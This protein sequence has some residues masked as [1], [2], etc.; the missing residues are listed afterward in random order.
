[1]IPK[2]LIS[3]F[4]QQSIVFVDSTEIDVDSVILATGYELRKPFLDA[5][6]VLVTNPKVRS[7]ET[8]RQALVSNTNYIF[9]LYRHIFS[10]SPTYPTT[11]LS[12]VGLPSAIANC[13]SDIAQSL[14]V[15]YSIRDPSILPSRDEMLYDLGIQEQKLRDEGLNPYTK[16]HRLPDGKRAS[17]YQDELVEYLEEKVDQVSSIV[18]KLNL[19]LFFRGPSRA[20]DKDSWKSGGEISIHTS[21]SGMA[22]NE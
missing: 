18:I 8:Y 15:A 11:A 17:D 22:G 9:P 19:A 13:P 3:H 6:N 21:T 4:T 1:M 16:G 7:N 14:F 20:M 5:G 12:F 10:L 2:P